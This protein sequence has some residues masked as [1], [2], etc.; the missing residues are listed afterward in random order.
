M[1]THSG[2]KSVTV[3]D[4]ARVAGVSKSTV[5]LVLTGSKKVSDTAKLKVEKAIDE[6]GYV[7]NRDAA[8]MRSR[9]S[10]LVA[11]VIN[12]L[13]NPYSAQLAVGLEQQIRKM[14]LFS[15]LVNS[16]EDVE[17]QNQLVRNLK[18]YNVAAF[19]MCPAPGTTAEWTNQLVDQGFP[20]V[21]IMREISGAKVATVLPDNFAGTNMATQH[22]LARGYRKIAFLGGRE[23]ISDYH[24]RLAG[25]TEAMVLANV[26]FSNQLC[27]QSDTNRNGGRQ[28]M[29]TALE[30]EP[31]L[32]AVVCF[33]DVVAYGAMEQM[34]LAGKI[35]GKDIAIV[36]F[37]DLEDSRLMTPALSTVHVDANKIGIAVCHILSN[38]KDGSRNKILVAVDLVV[39]ESS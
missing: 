28:A 26:P 33:S 12:D 38:I 29:T 5:S 16:G 25:F 23:T 2:S 37:D 3:H 14:G 1:V 6:T 32:E 7:Y 35:P 22:M 31:E 11:I 21:N 20:V 15:M 10:N 30:I 36:G 34:K 4:V 19:I 9:K 39:R 13:T 24:Q 18:E 8:S 27:I 17:T